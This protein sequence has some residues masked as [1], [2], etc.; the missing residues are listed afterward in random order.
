M[1]SLRTCT[2]FPLPP[3][4][5]IVWTEMF[6]LDTVFSIP[7]FC[8]HQ[9]NHFHLSN[10]H[11]HFSKVDICGPT[12]SVQ[13]PQ[14]L[15]LCQYAPVFVCNL[16]I[17]PIGKGKKRTRTSEKSTAQLYREVMIVNPKALSAHLVLVTYCLQ[18]L[19]R[20]DRGEA[21]PCL[22][23]PSSTRVSPTS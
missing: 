3:L 15:T 21:V 6:T 11:S 2:M 14:S 1:H 19:L 13:F 23:T 18:P 5:S 4:P 12:S 17:P 22:P 10:F 8:P 16:A 20:R 9:T 7:L